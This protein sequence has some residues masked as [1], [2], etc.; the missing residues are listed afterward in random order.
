MSKTDFDVII[1]GAGMAGLSA[2]RLLQASNKSVH[3]LEARDRVGGRVKSEY[4]DGNLIEVGGQWIAPDQTRLL[5]VIEELGLTTYRRYRDGEN[6]YIAPDGSRSTYVGELFPTADATEREMERLMEELQALS[7]EVDPDRPWEHSRAREF[8]TMSFA[9]WLH[10]RST[11]REA[12]DNVALFVAGAMLT[13]PADSFSMLQGLLMASSAGGF[14]DLVDP[15]F[16]LDA[17]V[18]GGM[19][20]VPM[21]LAEL[22][23]AD[24]IELGADVRAVETHDDHVIVNTKHSSLSASQVIV[25]IPP[26]LVTRIDFDPPLPPVKQQAYQHLSSGQVIKVQAWYD[27]PF[28][29]T[30]GLSGTAFSP[31]QVVHE[32]YDNT[33]PDF[34]GGTLVGFVSDRVAD[35]LYGLRD[36]ERK[37]EILRSFAA[38]FG[39][40]ALT[41]T[42]YYESDWVNEP[43]T[44]G[45]YGSSFA[46]SGLVR[47]GPA[48]KAPAGPIFFASSDIAGAGFT[49][50]EGAIRMG[51]AAAQD[52]LQTRAGN[53]PIPTRGSSGFCRLPSSSV[54]ARTRSG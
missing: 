44:R 53:E 20:Q 9:D 6:V 30:N 15:D 8:D 29:R 54:A 27:R 14:H 34:R 47:Y 48:S 23:G 51:E 18:T 45:A 3:L 41:P 16:I 24:N 7:L 25:A 38:Y 31:Y 11:N 26:H 13:K 40:E 1:I 39:S 4:F 49:H 32:A 17:R 36:S 52:I 37:A 5:E 35:R 50:I 46:I 33:T 19:H 21:A 28:W 2:A 22:V 12:I 42:I 10:T 43:Y